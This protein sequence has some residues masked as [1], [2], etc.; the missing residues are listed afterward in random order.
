MKPTPKI[1]VIGAGLAGL[2]AAYRLKALGL[3]VEV[4]EAKKRVGGR[5]FTVLMENYCGEMAEVEL[6]GQNITDGG[7]ALHFLNLAQELNLSI[8]EKIIDTNALVYEG[9]QPIYYK[10]L[11]AKHSKNF[12][13]L[14]ILAPRAQNIGQLIELFCEN[15]VLLK[16]ALFTRMMAYEGLHP[17]EQ[18]I[19]HNI[20]T[21]AYSL[22]GGVAKAHEAYSHGPDQVVTSCI[23]G[24]N[25]LLPLKLAKHLEGKIQYNK[26]LRKVSIQEAKAFLE[27]DNGS[28]CTYDY[29]ILAIPAATLKTIDFSGTQL[30]RSTLNKILSIRCGA[31]YK[32]ALAL[33][34]NRARRRNLLIK[35]NVIGFYNNDDSLQL[36][37]IN[38]QAPDI[39][40]FSSFLVKEVYRAPGGMIA[41]FVQ[42]EGANYEG[43]NKSVYYNWKDDVYSQ[44]SYTGY[45][46]TLSDDLDRY[47]RH[48]GVPYKTLFRPVQDR[49]FF[50]GEH[51][52]IL[53]CIG[54]MEAA[55]ESGERVAKA[56][57]KIQF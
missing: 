45:S 6:G 2:S 32:M 38:D 49:L 8:Q 24:G 21:L 43:Y 12:E 50:A 56:I 44:G 7:E 3:E 48:L 26:V 17:Y 39:K 16:K 14:P 55:V 54:T 31:N 42:P 4:F 52:T 9:A 33:D 25:A 11:V 22:S 15:N 37:Y 34:L 53:E 1:A 19:Y 51:T 27:F 20:E 29:V 41:P 23:K 36:L 46:T 35:D 10:E 13:E 47:S 18:S 30:A 57:H 28:V 5:V 40:A